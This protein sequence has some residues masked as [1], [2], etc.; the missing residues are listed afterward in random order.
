MRPHSSIEPELS[1]ERTVPDPHAAAEFKP[2]LGQLNQAATR[3]RDR[4]SPPATVDRMARIQRP[5]VKSNIR[6]ETMQL[7]EPLRGVV[8]ALAQ[9]H[10]RTEPEFIDVAVMWLDVITDFRRRDDAALEAE[11]AQRVF[12]Q[13]VPSD[14]SPAIRGVPLIPLRRP[15]AD[16]H[17]SSRPRVLWRY[18]K[19]RFQVMHLKRRPQLRLG[20]KSRVTQ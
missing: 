13:L 12:E 8:A 10:K 9:A 6:A 15:A 20:N 5:S 19:Y 1:L 18:P 4:V 7:D 14:S 11:R 17:G 2:R 3:V 16:A